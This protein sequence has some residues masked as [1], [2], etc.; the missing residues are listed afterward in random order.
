[1]V[2]AHGAAPGPAVLTVPKCALAPSCAQALPA[3][4]GHGGG[5]V[6]REQHLGDGIV[7]MVLRG[8]YRGDGIMRMALWGWH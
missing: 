3:P 5:R 4:A 2:R 7:G 6:A 1:M 8:W